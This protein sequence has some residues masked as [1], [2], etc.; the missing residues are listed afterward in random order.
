MSAFFS[1]PP[2]G[3]GKKCPP[4][5]SLATQLG[6]KLTELSKKRVIFV[7]DDGPLQELMRIAARGKCI[8]IVSAK[9]AS[10][11]KLFIR[12][13]TFDLAIL[14]VGILNG[15]GIAL[16]AWIRQ[17]F[18]SL[19]VI[20]LTGGSLDVISR[21]VQEVSGNNSPLIYQKPSSDAIILLTDLLRFAWA[22]PNSKV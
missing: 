15:D 13:E 8:D 17:S 22:R 1:N 21:R 19:N 9:T 14:D 3:L 6:R 18:P 2:F 20:F 12:T 5:E 11:A 10:E 4:R 7:D 16:Y